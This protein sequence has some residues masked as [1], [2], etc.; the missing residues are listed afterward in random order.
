MS[1]WRAAG[2]NYVRYSNIAANLVRQALKPELRAAAAKR[3]DSSVRLTPWKDGK[4]N[5]SAAAASE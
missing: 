5:R 4:P 3:D 1:S 2:L